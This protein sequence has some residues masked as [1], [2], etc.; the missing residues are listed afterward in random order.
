MTPQRQSVGADQHGY[1][2]GRH[3]R[4]RKMSANVRQC[5]CLSAPTLLAV[6]LG[7]KSFFEPGLGACETSDI[8]VPELGVLGAR[9]VEAHLG[10]ELL[11]VHRVLREEGHPPF[12]LIEPDRARNN[13]CNAAGITTARQAVAVHQLAP[14]LE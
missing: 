11:E 8:E 5:P 10:H 9:L 1:T 14:L 12:P 7:P 6:A 13:L 3:A 2:K 4:T